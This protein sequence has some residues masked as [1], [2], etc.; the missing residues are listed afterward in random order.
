[1]NE[2][3]AFYQQEAGDALSQNP[4][5]SALQSEA[6]AKL[7][8]LGFPSRHDEDWKYTSLIPFLKDPFTRSNT[9]TLSPSDLPLSQQMPMHSSSALSWVKKLPAGVILLP[10]SLAL[11]Q[12]PELV[13]QYLGKSFQEAHAFHCLN[14]AMLG[15]GVFLYV[16]AHVHL[17]EPIVLTQY[18]DL[19]G[20]AVYL[21]HVIVLEPESRAT[22]VEEYRGEQDLSYVTNVL[23][24]AFIG[25]KAEL[26]H[27]KIQREGLKAYHLAHLFAKQ[28]AESQ[29]NSHSFSLGGALVRSDLNVD[30]DGEYGRCFLNGVYAPG[31]GQ[32]VDHH[33]C[34]SHLHPHC[35]STQDYKGILQGQSRAV[36][37]GRVIVAR[38]A[39]AT[40]AKQQNKNLL[41]SALAEVDTKPQLEIF[42]DDV[43]CS[44]GATVGQLDEDALFYLATRGLSR[45]EAS[46]HLIAAFSQSNFNR[47]PCHALSTWIGQRFIEHL[48]VEH[49]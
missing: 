7:G 48:G 12:H 13:E 15:A 30:F 43:L 20:Q 4:R 16:P 33:T 44:H 1:M 26:T 25:E 8:K 42:A 49:V 5:V 2:I 29:F 22:V 17:Q 39:I 14:T 34:V 40:D 19:A 45:A 11:K 36:F 31:E 46:A 28:A 24:E 18:Q 3:L 35:L 32:H 27:Y 47:I 10:L 23:T 41:L 37:N 38:N 6:V 9:S 21:R